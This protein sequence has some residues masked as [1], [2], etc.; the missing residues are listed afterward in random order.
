MGDLGSSA[1]CWT[2]SINPI[3]EECSEY[4]VLDVSVCRNSSAGSIRRK[5]PS[6]L[7]FTLPSGQVVN[8]PAAVVD[9]GRSSRASGGVQL[10]SRTGIVHLCLLSVRLPLARSRTPAAHWSLPSGFPVYQPQPLSARHAFALVCSL[11]ASKYTRQ[12][13]STVD[14]L[15]S[16]VVQQLL[17]PFLFFSSQVL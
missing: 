6:D 1:T 10:L 7:T 5:Y 3:L 2:C 15:L 8:K 12:S 16:V 14:P 13:T 9:F 11:T 17:S 4:G